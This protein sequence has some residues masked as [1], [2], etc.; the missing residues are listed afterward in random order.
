MNKNPY[1]LATY[2]I[3]GIL[4]YF[5]LDRPAAYFFYNIHFSSFAEILINFLNDLGLG[6]IYI[7]GLPLAASIAWYLKKTNITK[8]LIFLWLC[9]IFAGITCDIFKVIFGRARPQ[10]LFEY[11]HYGFYWFKFNA[12]YWSFPSGHTTVIA[13]VMAGLCYLKPRGK[14]LFIT[15]AL[16]ISFMRIVLSQHYISDVMAAFLLAF[17][18]VHFLHAFYEKKGY[19]LPTL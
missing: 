2:V 3:L 11:Q 17:V 13:A 4:S 7:I 9:V 12:Y 18:C 6:W 14:I 16:V 10:E 1:F 15:I 19:N 5:F 8:I